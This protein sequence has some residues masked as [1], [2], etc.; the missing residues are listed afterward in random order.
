MRTACRIHAAAR[1]PWLGPARLRLRPRLRLASASCLTGLPLRG[2]HAAGSRSGC[3]TRLRIP[4]VS[5]L[6]F[7]A[8]TSTGGSKPAACRRYA[9]GNRRLQQ[10]SLFALS[11]SLS[12]AGSH[13]QKRQRQNKIHKPGL[14]IR[15]LRVRFPS[16]SLRDSQTL[17]SLRKSTL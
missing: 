3:L 14:S 15:R 5:L 11:L 8:A 12:S 17:R 16:A 4:P 13:F 1:R 2:V 7:F 6:V 10:R 9:A